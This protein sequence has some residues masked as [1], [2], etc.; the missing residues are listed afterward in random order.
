MADVAGAIFTRPPWCEPYPAARS[1]SA[2][3][4]ADSGSP[5]FVLAVALHGEE[6]AGFA[7]GM[8]C[9]RLAVLAGREPADDFTLRELGVLPEARGQGLGAALHDAVLSAAEP[10]RRWLATH[11]AA[12]EAMGLYRA[13]GWRSVMLTGENRL[14]M[15]STPTKQY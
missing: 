5:G 1:L 8:R 11:P 12:T 4:L 10:G 7:Y 3:L 9:S 15:T 13:Q 14:I 6:L 2:R